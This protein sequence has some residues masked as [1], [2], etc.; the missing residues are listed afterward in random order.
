MFK[1][2]VI[3]ILGSVHDDD[4]L[5][6]KLQRSD[7]IITKKGNTRDVVSYFGGRINPLKQ[8]IFDC[9]D[10]GLIKEKLKALWSNGKKITIS[11]DISLIDRKTL[12][13]II[14]IIGKATLNSPIQILLIYSLAKYTPPSGEYVINS[15][16]KPVSPFF[17]GWAQR[18]GLPTLSIVGLGYEK[19]KALGAVEYIESSD[20][21]LFFPQ[22]AEKEYSS[23]VEVM[24]EALIKSAKS[25][26][27]MKYNVEQPTDTLYSL[28][29]ILSSVKNKYKVVLFPFGPKI[30]YALSLLAAI[31]HP[32]ASVWYVSGE[33]GD[34][35]S[36]QDR[37]ISSMTGFE[38]TIQINS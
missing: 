3:E 22:S 20:N 13:E 34:K 36:S 2:Y 14:S 26:E 11:L 6:K 30:F 1:S 27:L 24:N 21:F 33:C 16:V 9:L 29:S 19:D 28:D 8:I 17:S 4:E 7:F 10:T 38:F 18:P 31:I 23:D 12:A 25:K 35:D 37:E 15:S 32:E 5:I